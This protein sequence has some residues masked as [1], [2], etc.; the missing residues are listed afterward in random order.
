MN[1]KMKKKNNDKEIQMIK[2]LKT[3]R[4]Y[5]KMKLYSK[6]NSCNNNNM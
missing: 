6:Y 2:Y 5:T 3:K 4:I 1:E